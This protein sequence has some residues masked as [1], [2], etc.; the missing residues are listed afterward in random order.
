MASAA[1]WLDAD[2]LGGFAMGRAD[3]VRTRRYH[4]ILT[5]ATTPPTGRVM[6]VNGVE[7]WIET[8]EGRFALSSHRYAPDI[9]HPDGV[10]RLV[11]FDTEP[12][13][14]WTFRLPSGVEVIH[15]LVG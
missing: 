12:W 6:L 14:A 2:G 11:A 10:S 7:A 5:V 4:G 1:E 15:E 8:E 3:G 13:P 9:T